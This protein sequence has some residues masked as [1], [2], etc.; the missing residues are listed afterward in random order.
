[1]VNRGRIRLTGANPQPI[2]LADVNEIGVYYKDKNG[3]WQ[4]IEPEIVHEVSGG[5][6]KSTLRHDI[7]KPDRDGEVNGRESKLLLPR[8]IEFLIYAPDG[9]AVAESTGAFPAALRQ[10]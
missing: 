1:M 7:V 6:L 8:P 2:V 5:F 3:K 4:A 10:P 9:V